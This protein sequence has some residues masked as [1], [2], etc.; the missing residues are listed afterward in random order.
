MERAMQ[1][2]KAIEAAIKADPEA[3]WWLLQHR[4]DV[5]KV[6]GPWVPDTQQGDT[7]SWTPGRC[8]LSPTGVQ[9]AYSGILDSED[10]RYAVPVVGVGEDYGTE[11]DADEAL[12]EAGYMLVPQL[13]SDSSPKVLSGAIAHSVLVSLLAD[14][15]YPDGSWPAMVVT[16]PPHGAVERIGV[17]FC[18]GA[19]VL[20]TAEDVGGVPLVQLRE[21]ILS[22]RGVQ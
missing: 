1:R 20:L 14:Q 13:P 3:W 21:M 19:D 16:M 6:A 22:R 15:R 11:A 5:T 7:V 8:R 12:R 2:A 18:E 4:P 10:D 17:V 9:L